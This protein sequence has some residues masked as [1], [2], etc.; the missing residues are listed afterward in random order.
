MQPACVAGRVEVDRDAPVVLT[1]VAV[2]SVAAATTT[3][4]YTASDTGGR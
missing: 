1:A 3:L 2:H 4:M